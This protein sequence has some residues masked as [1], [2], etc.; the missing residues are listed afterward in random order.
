MRAAIIF[1][2]SS[3]IL[4]VNT[5]AQALYGPPESFG[6]PEPAAPLGL[7]I[8]NILL[9][10][11]MAVVFLVGLFTIFKKLFLLLGTQFKRK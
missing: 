8:K 4:R 3:L 10:G 2:I 7:F 1:V 6:D 5:L 9:Y 11:S